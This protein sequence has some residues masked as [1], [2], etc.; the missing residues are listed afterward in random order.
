MPEISV[1]KKNSSLIVHCGNV[2]LRKTPEVFLVKGRRCVSESRALLDELPKMHIEQQVALV[3]YL[4]RQEEEL[5]YRL[6]QVEELQEVIDLVNPM[7]ESR[8]ESMLRV[9]LVRTGVLG[10]EPQMPVGC[11]SGTRYVDLGNPRLRIALEYQGAV[12]FENAEKR[13]QDSARVNE[14]RAAGWVVIEVTWPDLRDQ[15]RWGRFLKELRR[16]ISRAEDARKVR[17]IVF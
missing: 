2:I 17:R 12:H 11:E 13:S 14:L 3:D 8:P 7:A 6:K 4:V 5:Y 16:Q 15:A 9:R 10:F 1:V